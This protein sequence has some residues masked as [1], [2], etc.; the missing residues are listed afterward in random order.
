MSESDPSQVEQEIA[1]A[2]RT[3]PQH[4]QEVAALLP[5]P[6]LHHACMVG[7]LELVRALVDAGVPPD[8]YPETD[9][10]D[11]LPPLTW[12]ARD[13][14]DAAANALQ[15]AAFLIEH[16]DDIDEGN[17]LAAA[18]EADDVSMVRLLLAA[19]ADE[20]LAR[21]E[22]G[23]TQAQLLDASLEPYW[24]TPVGADPQYFIALNSDRMICG[25]GLSGVDA[26]SRAQLKVDAQM[27]QSKSASEE[28]VAA[29][30]RGDELSSKE[31]DDLKKLDNH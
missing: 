14:K 6:L 17:P 30:L 31:E 22:V 11:D 18:L 9:D 23:Q 24:S 27:F 7:H 12:L 2:V 4:L 21:Q 3:L 26:H 16:C 29:F 20:E 19:G 13:R 28:L 1:A 5:F 10:E 8:L 25:V 15:V